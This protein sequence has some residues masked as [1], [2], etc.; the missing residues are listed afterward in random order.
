MKRTILAITILLSSFSAVLAQESTDYYVGKWNV[1]I[2]E[3]PNGDVTIPM[4]FESQEGK[5]TGY[6]TDESGEE[7]EMDSATLED[8]KLNLAFYIAGYDVTMDLAEED[9]NE[10]RG[11]VMNMLEAIASRDVQVAA[12]MVETEV[13]VAEEGDSMTPYFMGVWS[14]LIEGTPNGDATVEMRFEQEEGQLKGYVVNPEDQSLIEMT[15]VEADDD[16]LE[17]NFSMMGYDL[18]LTLEKEDDDKAVG[19]LMDMFTSTATRVKK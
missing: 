8:G 12:E 1:L 14:V 16:E 2:K 7:K 13:E 18:T 19:S 6:F 11:M 15:S 10:M 9:E 3:T 4:R 5:Y 17:A